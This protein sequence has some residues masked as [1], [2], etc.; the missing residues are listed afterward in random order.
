MRTFAVKNEDDEDL[1][2]EPPVGEDDD[3][4][5]SPRNMYDELLGDGSSSNNKCNT[6]R[7]GT[8]RFS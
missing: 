8:S 4:D 7:K 3:L 1:T 6:F 5:Y 2:E